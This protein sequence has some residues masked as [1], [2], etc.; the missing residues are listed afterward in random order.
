MEWMFLRI[1]RALTTLDASLIFLWPDANYTDILHDY[2]RKAER[3]AL[4]EMMQPQM[5]ARVMG[6]MATGMEIQDR[7]NEYTMFQSSLI[8]QHAQVFHGTATKFSSAFGFVVGQFALLVLAHGIIIFLVFLQQHYPE[9]IHF[10]GPQIKA[11]ASVFPKLDTPIWL[12]IL[13]F[14]AY[15]FWSMRKLKLRLLATEFKGKP[16]ATV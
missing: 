13:W 7:F 14:D 8:R 5:A 16:V 9:Q 15:L 12:G 11:L 4:R 3:R 1:R 6:S 2:L 10:M